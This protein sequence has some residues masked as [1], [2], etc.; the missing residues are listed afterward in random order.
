MKIRKTPLKVKNIWKYVQLILF[1]LR[2]YFFECPEKPKASISIVSK[3]IKSNN[4][5]SKILYSCFFIL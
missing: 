5:L 3:Y 2:V 1:V 4:V